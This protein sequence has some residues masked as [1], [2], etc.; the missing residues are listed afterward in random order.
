MTSRRIVVGIPAR[1]GA[2]RLP[3]KP[4]KRILDL[5]IIEHVYHR[6]CM[7]ALPGEVFIAACDEAVRQVV[8]AVGGRVVMTDPDVPRPALRVAQAMDALGLVDEDIIV[9]VQGDEP[10]I[11]PEMIDQAI[12][13]FLDHPDDLCVCLMA[14]CTEDEWLDPN[15]IK[16]IA[17]RR[18]YAKYM[19]R[20]PI[21]SN[22]RHDPGP[23]FKQVCVFP[24][25]VR[26]LRRFLALEETPCE[27]AES[28]ELLRGIEHGLPIKMVETH[29]Q[30]KSVDTEADRLLVEEMMRVDD[31]YP[32]YRTPYAAGQP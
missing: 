3:G 10:L 1:L 27:R 16:V 30:T 12:A 22:T 4:L 13:A 24:F 23:R 2:S 6:A 19:S 7:A 29:W 26:S 9:T 20:S 11:R 18:G 25:T 21:P 15:E 32:R 5:S 8:E 14:P 31:L 28:I 17:D